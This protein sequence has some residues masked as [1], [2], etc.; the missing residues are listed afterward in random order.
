LGAVFDDDDDI[1]ATQQELG[2][3]KRKETI[4]DSSFPSDVID[5]SLDY[6]IPDS[7]EK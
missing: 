4:D 6:L 7:L 2:V 3:F 5:K 1:R